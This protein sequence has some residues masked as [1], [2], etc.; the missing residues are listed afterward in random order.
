MRELR[1]A[2]VL[3][4]A[5]LGMGCAGNRGAP[6]VAPGP[7]VYRSEAVGAPKP[8]ALLVA[9]HFSGS[10][11]AFWDV[12]IQSLGIPVRTL[13]P[14]G[15]RPRRDG[16]TWFQADHEEKTW[17]G[18]TEDVERMAERLAELI[19]EVRAEHP[20]IHRVVVTGF[21][22]GGDL[23][24]MLAIRHPELVDAAMPMGTRLLGDPGQEQPV[25]RRVRVL[26]GE[27]DA[28]IPV[29]HTRE[30]V[31]EL[32]GRGVPIDLRTYPDLGHDVSPALLE[33]WR[34]FLRQSLQGPID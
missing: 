10:T 11:P 28:I 30:R 6:P 13:L 1:T 14:Q 26:Q 7:L 17:E 16:F 18:K 2:A 4:A 12:P 34:E 22:Y 21:S 23:A 27:Q 8:E 25:A 33:D 9:L 20:E 31:A 5:M 29:Q 32:K 24:W 19:R 15:P 3:L